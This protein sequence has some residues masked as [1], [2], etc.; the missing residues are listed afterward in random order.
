V[1]VV[2]LEHTLLKK[3]ILLGVFQSLE[4]EGFVIWEEKEAWRFAWASEE[5]MDRLNVMKRYKALE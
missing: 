3:Q 5:I 2:A 4:D 1:I